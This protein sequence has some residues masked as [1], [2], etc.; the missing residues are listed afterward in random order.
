[1]LVELR[2]A[3]VELLRSSFEL[4]RAGVQRPLASGNLLLGFPRRLDWGGL[5]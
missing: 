3:S 2:S 5:W 4:F 1:L